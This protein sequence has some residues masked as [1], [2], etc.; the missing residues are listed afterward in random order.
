MISVDSFRLS[1]SAFLFSTAKKRES[2]ATDNKNHEE[3][4]IPEATPPAIDLKTNPLAT[5][6]NSINGTFFNL[7][8]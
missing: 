6:K 8:Q 3:I 7:K 2:I 5:Q 1:I 4:K